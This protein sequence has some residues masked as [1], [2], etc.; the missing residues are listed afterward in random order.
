MRHTCLSAHLC[1]DEG[2]PSSRQSVARPTPPLTG[3]SSQTLLEIRSATSLPDAQFVCA[4]RATL[5]APLLVSNRNWKCASHDWKSSSPFFFSSFFFN[6]LFL[7][8]RCSYPVLMSERAL[9]AG[10]RVGTVPQTH[11]GIAN[12][13]RSSSEAC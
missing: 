11:R 1:A 8:S 2:K 3:R 9:C 6:L 13:L 5:R 10:R 7:L 12:T 4:Q